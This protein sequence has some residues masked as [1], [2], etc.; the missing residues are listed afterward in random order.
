VPKIGEHDTLDLTPIDWVLVIEK[1]V[2]S[3]QTLQSAY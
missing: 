3:S 2:R 1:E